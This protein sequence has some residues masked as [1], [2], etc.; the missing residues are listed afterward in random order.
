MTNTIALPCLLAYVGNKQTREIHKQT[1]RIILTELYPLCIYTKRKCFCV[2][3][4]RE[5]LTFAPHNIIH[6]IDPAKQSCPSVYL[7]TTHSDSFK[8]CSVYFVF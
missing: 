5:H 1:N 8:S 7:Y 6:S 2:L 4:L 3:D